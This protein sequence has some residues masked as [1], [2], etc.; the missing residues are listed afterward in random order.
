MNLSDCCPDPLRPQGRISNQY[1]RSTS[2]NCEKFSET[3]L[4]DCEHPEG[5]TI[6]TV[7][8]GRTALDAPVNDTLEVGG[9]E[10]FRLNELWRL[11]LGVHK[12]PRQVVA[13]PRGRY[14][15]IEVK[16]RT[17]LPEDDAILGILQFEDWLAK[18]KLRN[19]PSILMAQGN[20]MQD[21]AHSLRV[22]AASAESRLHRVRRRLVES[23]PRFA[24]I[25]PS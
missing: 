6:K 9:P 16:E 21:L 10:K 19:A 2:L 22:S 7:V 12:D 13:D 3:V 20:S 5:I 1:L 11:F 18:P 8:I 15:D 23:Y 4:L 24:T 25:A 14:Y 17:L